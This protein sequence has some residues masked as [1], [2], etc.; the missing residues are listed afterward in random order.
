MSWQ[1]QYMPPI[2]IGEHQNFKFLGELLDRRAQIVHFLAA[3][4]RF[5]CNQ[6]MGLHPCIR[7]DLFHNAH[8]GIGGGS[9]DEENLVVL[10]VELCKRYEIGFEARL[11]PLAW[12]KH[13]YARRIESLPG[14]C[15]SAARSR[16]TA[17]RAR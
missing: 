11:H 12:A 3:P 7:G 5:S 1:T 16:A 17:R 2:G 10:P 15:A 9:K 8:R 13:R 6:H 14:R 4:R